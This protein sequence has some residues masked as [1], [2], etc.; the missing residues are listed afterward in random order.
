[1][2]GVFSGQFRVLHYFEHWRLDT[3]RYEG[4][5]NK[6]VRSKT[7]K[8]KLVEEKKKKKEAGARFDQV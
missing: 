2:R 3:S 6:K 7:D 8:V 1:M 4:D 5:T